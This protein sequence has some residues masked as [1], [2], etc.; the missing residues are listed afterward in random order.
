SSS[1]VDHTSKTSSSSNRTSTSSLSYQNKLSIEDRLVLEA[2][3]S[4]INKKRL[5]KSGAC[6]ENTIYK[7]TIDFSHEHPLHSYI[8]N[9]NDET[10]KAAFK[11]DKVKEILEA[12]SNNGFNNPLPNEM[13]DMLFKLDKK[14]TFDEIYQAF[15]YVEV[16]RYDQRTLYWLKESILNY[17]DLFYDEKQITMYTEKDLL[18]EVYGFIRRSRTL[19]CTRT[20]TDSGSMASSEV[21]NGS[22]TLGT[23]QALARQAAGDHADLV[24]KSLSTEVACVEIG[25]ENLGSKGTKELQEK[26][27]KTPKM[28]KAF[29]ARITEQY[30][31]A[32]T[33]EIKII[34][35]IISGM[36]ITALE[37]S[38]KKGSIAL[39]SSSERLKM[40]ESIKQIPALL[41]PVL[42]LV[43]NCTQAIK[44]TVDYIDDVSSSFSL[45]RIPAANL[46]FFPPCFV[47]GTKNDK[48]RKTSEI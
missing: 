28:M 5:L 20:E 42:A 17:I 3:H 2:T 4:K 43:Y 9:T 35:Y 18:E 19:C 29:C 33:E 30:P 25:L 46:T 27:F 21:K 44:N 13:L 24:F 37:M 12:S 45:N 26:L 41:P 47:P 10:W 15:K 6:V 32:K 11:P 31:Q 1:G 34:G 14:K 8:I 38:F 48:K 22:R 36:Y 39:I 7:K 16:D 40:P 23:N